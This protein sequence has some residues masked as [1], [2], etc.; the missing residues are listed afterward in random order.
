MPRAKEPAGYQIGVAIGRLNLAIGK[1]AIQ[2][3]TPRR[4]VY[5][6]AT[7]NF[8]AIGWLVE[9]TLASVDGQRPPSIFTVVLD[10]DMPNYVQSSL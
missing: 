9:I 10:E 6:R 5:D 8:K 1:A 2:Y 7:G 4:R 3:Y